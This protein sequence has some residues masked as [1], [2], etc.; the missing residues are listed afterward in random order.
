M[1]WISLPLAATALAIPPS[2]GAADTAPESTLPPTYLPCEGSVP[3]FNPQ[4]CL[5]PRMTVEKPGEPAESACRDRIALVR[6]AQGQPRL[7]RQPASPERPYLI[8]AV[9]KRIDGCAVMQMHHDVNDLR[10]LPARPD[11]PAKVYRGG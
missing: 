4:G 1:H 11:G 5:P 7:E 10:P 2:G 3:V 8:A 9:D 6:E